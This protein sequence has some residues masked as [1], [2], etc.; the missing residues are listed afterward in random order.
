MNLYNPHLNKFFP[1]S[2]LIGNKISKFKITKNDIEEM[3]LSTTRYTKFENNTEA[4]KQQFANISVGDNKEEGIIM[5]FAEIKVYNS[6][7][8]HLK[9]LA[10][11][12]TC[13]ICESNPPA[14]KLDFM[15]EMII[16]SETEKEIKT[17]IIFKR[18][19]EKLTKVDNITEQ[20]N[21]EEVLSQ[22]EGKTV[23]VEYNGEANKEEK[24]FVQLIQY[25]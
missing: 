3:R 22:I 10:D 18:D 7:S 21:L 14:I 4:D 1:G 24:T 8:K 2:I 23:A 13:I 17:F 20:E 16:D 11:D 9:K 5:G 25:I 12:N 15:A 19:M 6:C